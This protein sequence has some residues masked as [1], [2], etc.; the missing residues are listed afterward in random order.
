M[1]AIWMKDKAIV[2]GQVSVSQLSC[3]GPVDAILGTHTT[4]R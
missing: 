1:K 3:S 4:E 2:T